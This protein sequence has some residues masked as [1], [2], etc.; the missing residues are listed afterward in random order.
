M[1]LHVIFIHFPI[2][3][4]T[5][6]AF[7]E[8]LRFKKLQEKIYWFYIKA[9]LSIAGALGSYVAYI[10][11]D[12]LEDK[13]SAV[14]NLLDIHSIWA[15][16]SVIIFSIIAFAYLIEWVK[17]SNLI[18]S[19]INSFF[20]RVWFIKQRVSEIIL[21]P[22]I[23]IPLAI[24]GIIAITITGALGGIIVY[25]KNADFITAFIYNIFVR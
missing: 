5:L 18:H 6:Y 14:G 4:F 15:T 12:A 11:G 13:F 24:F 19:D 25:G 10:S 20:G 21:S 16:I 23:I 22:V 3:L 7:F 8:V 17:R 9:T 1:N 2:A